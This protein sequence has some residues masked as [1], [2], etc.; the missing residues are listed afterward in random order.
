MIRQ[1]RVRRLRPKPNPTIPD[2][3]SP[4]S[5]F[6]APR[7]AP[8]T[9]PLSSSLKDAFCRVFSNPG[10]LNSR[11]SSRFFFIAVCASAS[12]LRPGFTLV[13]RRLINPAS[14]RLIG[15]TR[16]HKSLLSSAYK[17]VVRRVTRAS[18]FHAYR[19]PIAASARSRAS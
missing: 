15:Q 18:R 13:K 19:R 7:A 5:N 4:N 2:D 6:C 3:P 12:G 11:V 9:R 17:H 8:Q 16:N 10:A 1:P 14:R